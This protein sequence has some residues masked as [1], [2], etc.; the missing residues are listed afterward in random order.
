MYEPSTPASNLG[1]GEYFGARSLAFDEPMT[2]TVKA[3]GHVKCAKMSKEMFDQEVKPIV[4]FI[5]Q[6]AIAY[7]SFLNHLV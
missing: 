3:N 2:A 5:Q 4:R 1:C 6:R 7:E